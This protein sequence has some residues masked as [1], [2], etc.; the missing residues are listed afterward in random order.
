MCIL[1]SILSVRCVVRRRYFVTLL[2]AVARARVRVCCR[3]ATVVGGGY[4]TARGSCVL[5]VLA[6]FDMRGLRV[7]GRCASRGGF[8]ALIVSCVV[9]VLARA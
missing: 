2:P 4:N 6:A 3:C 5:S 7:K 9:L 8:V 1:R